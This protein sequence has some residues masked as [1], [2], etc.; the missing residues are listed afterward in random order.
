VTG[1]G[2]AAAKGDALA[3][4]RLLRD[5][6][7]AAAARDALHLRLGGLAGRLRQ[8]HRRRLVEDALDLLRGANRVRL[9]SLPN[10][11]LVAVAPPGAERL[12]EAEAVFGTLLAS[13]DEASPPPVA[14]LR[15]PEE[16]AALFAAVE[17]S[18]APAP[19]AQA[20]PPPPPPAAA[21]T[22]GFTA[23]DLATMERALAGADLSSFLRQR[24][25]C[26]LGPAD[27][28]AEVAWREWRVAL[29]EVLA[30]VAPQAAASDPASASPWLL[31][32]LRR[33]LDR[34]LLAALARPERSVALG[35]AALRLSPASVHTQEFARFAEALGPAGRAAVVVGTRAEDVLADPEGFAA[36]RDACR[37]RGFR[38]AL[39]D[40]DAAVLPLLQP[41]RRLG[42]DLVH[43][44]WSP[45]LPAAAAAAAPADGAEVVLTGADTAAAIGWSWERGGALFEGRLLRPRG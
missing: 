1:A 10:A 6:V 45:G 16:A 19:A 39:M 40:A 43:L 11:D 27:S 15:L 3:L 17:A 2:V 7:A 23:G 44:R 25:V 42:L 29:H 38:P 31:R 5:A 30:A 20:P 24:P 22:A 14:R 28:G 13:G 32:R 18:L 41:P 8:P 37:A 21:G 35:A 36:A 26:R 33:A 4:I 12:R 34:R 9:F